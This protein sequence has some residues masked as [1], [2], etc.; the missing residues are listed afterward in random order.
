MLERALSILLAFVIA[1]VDL[2]AQD[3]AASKRPPGE[4]T[5]DREEGNFLV[6]ETAHYT[7]HVQKGALNKKTKAP[8][9]EIL[10]DL[11]AKMEL[12]FEKYAAAF[13][14]KGELSQ[15]PVLR[16]YK[17]KTAYV[18]SGGPMGSAAYY[19]SKTKELVGY[20]DSADTGI[21]FQ[22]L[23]HEGCHQFF[24]LAFPG[25]YDSPDLPMWF[26]EGLA[27]CFGASYIEGKDLIIFS[28]SGV[29]A[30]RVNMIKNAVQTKSHPAL[31][32]LLEMGR[33]PFMANAVTHYAMSWS[34][35]HFL[36][37]APNLDSGGGK[38]KESV[39]RL[40]EGFKQG[41]PKAEV[42]KDAFRVGD[43]P[44]EL[45][46]LEQEWKAYVATLRAKR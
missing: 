33:Q 7:I 35:V 38:Y 10:H 24:D 3:K 36:W 1:S 4:K 29:A 13:H 8:D 31:K 45:D 16:V 12:L 41:K 32:D 20:E 19:N 23:C 26:S 17:D 21:L 40:I 44:L 43:K 6:G 5:A 11:K 34:F 25:F 18:Q 15:K 14:F 39:K 37:N 46:Q 9:K 2:E 30:W 22:I 27:D 42:Y 28:L